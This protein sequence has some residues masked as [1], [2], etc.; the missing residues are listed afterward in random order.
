M[1][2]V[3]ESPNHSHPRHS[4][5]RHSVTQAPAPVPH[6][7]QSRPRTGGAQSCRLTWPVLRGGGAERGDL[8]ADLRD[9]R[10]ADLADGRRR[11]RRQLGVRVRV[12]RRV[13]CARG[14]AGQQAHAAEQHGSPQAA[15]ALFHARPGRSPPAGDVLPPRSV[16]PPATPPGCPT[17]APALRRRSPGHRLRPAHCAPAGCRTETPR[18]RSRQ[19]H[20]QLPTR[21]QQ[22]TTAKNPPRDRQR[23]RRGPELVGP[24]SVRAPL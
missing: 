23:T 20:W 1:T 18:A 24:S 9:E 2:R 17:A 10:R 13:R 11:R 12:R 15:R 16:P 6:Y 4:P 8:R 7:I 3:I 22:I 19:Q 14:A 21:R 5:P